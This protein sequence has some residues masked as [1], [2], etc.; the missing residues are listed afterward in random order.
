MRSPLRQISIRLR[1]SLVVIT[2]AW[3]SAASIALFIPPRLEGMAQAA[4]ESKGRGLVE[5]L[6]FNLVA[7]LEF[8]DPLGVEEAVASIRALSGIVGVRVH[9]S[10][11]R[12]LLDG[13][14]EPTEAKRVRELWVSAP[15][16]GV[17]GL[18]GTVRIGLSQNEV[19]AEVA[20]NRGGILLLSG[21]VALLGLLLG[22]VLA[23]LITRPV[24]ELS[25]AAE[26]MSMGNL[27][28]RV[29]ASNRD[30]LGRLA[31]AFNSMAANLQVSRDRIEESSANLAAKVEERTHE[32]RLAMEAAEAANQAKSVFLAN[33]SHEIRTPLNG[34]IG[35]TELTL[36]TELDGEQQEYLTIVEDSAGALL[37]VIND[38]LDFS[39]I[40]ADKLEIERIG[41]DIYELLESILDAFNLRAMQSDLEFVC[42]LDPA[43]PRNVLGDPARIRQVLV[44]LVGNAIKFTQEG[45]IVIG[46]GPSLDATGE[47]VGL[48]LSVHDSGIGLDEAAQRNIFKAFTQADASTTRMYGGTGLGL[49]I[50]H[51]LVQLMGGTLEVESELGNGACFHFTLPM[52]VSPGTGETNAWPQGQGRHILIATRWSKTRTVLGRLFEK[53]GYRVTLQ[54]SLSSDHHDTRSLLTRYDKVLCDSQA[55][56]DS[57]CADPNVFDDAG[58]DPG[59]R[60]ILLTRLGEPQ[61]GWARAA[62]LELPTLPLPVKPIVLQSVLGDEAAHIPDAAKGVQRI[63]PKSLENVRVLLV[64][65]NQVNRRFVE[66]LLTKLGCSLVQAQDGREGLDRHAEEEFDIVLC[67]VQMPVLDGYEF[68]RGGCQETGAWGNDACAHHRAHGQ[69]AEGRS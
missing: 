26:A 40:E 33:M 20:R 24:N 57:R 3:L 61:G 39:K 12:F 43:L 62:G 32:L 22:T 14:E 38:V 8:D 53:L 17:D 5:M 9:N 13:P 55:L 47:F 68:A 41:F 2:V 27:E 35:M 51:R 25:D 42:D 11:G 37:T 18:L 58:V 34:I 67:D 31:R 29:D 54:D 66:I 7:P 15:I 30:E 50:S 49:A 60:M 23:R 59:D 21:L 19:D 46:M 63:R 36:N 52:E 4:L 1:L 44:N 16:E 69:R 10:Q 56:A 48:D 6:A 65:D 28:V 45:S 64:E